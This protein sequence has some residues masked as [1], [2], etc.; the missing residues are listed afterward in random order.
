M[1]PET[2]DQSARISLTLAAPVL[3]DL[4]RLAAERS[5]PGGK[6]NRSEAVR[7]LLREY[8]GRTATA[9]KTRNRKET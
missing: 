8:R 3:T 5:E 4:D 2:P 9:T 6:P 7:F 1:P